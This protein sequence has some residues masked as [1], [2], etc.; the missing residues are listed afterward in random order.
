MP[1]EI[2]RKFLVKDKNIYM[3]FCCT[4]NPCKKRCFDRINGEEIHQG[5]LSENVRVRL[6]WSRDT[7]YIAIKSNRKGIVRAE[8]EYKIPFDEAEEIYSLCQYKVEKERHVFY[9]ND[10]Y[11]ELDIFKGDNDGLVMAEVELKS[12][13]EEIIIPGWIDKEVSDDERYY[14]YMLASNPYKYWGLGDQTI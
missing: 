8:Y 14:N 13:N 9:C 11:W 5:Y 2:E 1:L 6:N 12:E 4:P 10:K 3:D 7:A